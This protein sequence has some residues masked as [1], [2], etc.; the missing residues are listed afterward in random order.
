MNQ[1]YQLDDELKVLEDQEGQRH[2]G[3]RRSVRVPSEALKGHVEAEREFRDYLEN[4]LSDIMAEFDSQEAEIDKHISHHK[5]FREE[6]KRNQWGHNQGFDR[7]R[8][9]RERQEQDLMKEKRLL[10]LKRQDKKV[11]ILKELRESKKE[12]SPFKSLF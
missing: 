2:V 6:F 3:V 4:V 12:L 9:Q 8:L 7:L 10:R 11:A 1:K 5:F